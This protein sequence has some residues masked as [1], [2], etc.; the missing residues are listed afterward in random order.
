ML[1]FKHKKNKK[2]DT[3]VS[4]NFFFL[5]SHNFFDGNIFVLEQTKEL[6]PSGHDDLP[7]AERTERT[8]T[9]DRLSNP[10]AMIKQRLIGASYF[11]GRRDYQK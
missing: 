8:K 3:Q 2:F 4:H 6:V 11:N 7:S 9:H 1:S 5:F 10:I